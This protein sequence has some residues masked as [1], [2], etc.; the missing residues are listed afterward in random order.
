MGDWR[1]RGRGRVEKGGCGKTIGEKGMEEDG[2][3]GKIGTRIKY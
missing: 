2:V 1:G 3:L